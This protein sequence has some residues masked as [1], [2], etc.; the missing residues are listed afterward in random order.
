MQAQV[1]LID[2]KY[3]HNVGNVLRACSSSRSFYETGASTGVSRFV[4]RS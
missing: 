1:L 2:P 3:P 4:S